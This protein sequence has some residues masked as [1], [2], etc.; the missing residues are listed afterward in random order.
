MAEINK[1]FILF[2]VQQNQTYSFVRWLLMM[3]TCGMGNMK[4]YSILKLLVFN[5]EKGAGLEDARGLDNK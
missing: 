4:L 1:Q 3:G 5:P 2:I